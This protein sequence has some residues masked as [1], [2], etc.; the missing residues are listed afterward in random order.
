MA[1]TK[2][3]KVIRTTPEAPLKWPKLAKAETYKNKTTF[4]TQQVFPADSEYAKKLIKAIDKMADEA[5]EK[6]IAEDKRPQ[7]KKDANPWKLAPKPYDNELDKEGEETG[8]VVF[9]FKANAEGKKK[10]GSPW[11]RD[12]L[13]I[14]DAKGKAFRL[15][16]D[17][18]NGTIA[19]VS[20]EMRPYAASAEVGAGVSLS[21][22]AVQIIKLVQGGEGNAEDYGFKKRD[23]GFDADE[24][25][26]GDEDESGDKTESDSGSSSDDDE[27]F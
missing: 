6:A 4:N 2:P 10:D 21:I 23:D 18:W 26:E 16:D 22:E 27:D 5:L 3:K 15:K 12:R 14:F 8:N 13:K 17:P 25:P 1:D 24:A 20:Y 11:K 19:C 7:K 9:K